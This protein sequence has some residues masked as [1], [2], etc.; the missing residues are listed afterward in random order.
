MRKEKQQP[1]R[2]VFIPYKVL[3]LIASAVVMLVNG[4]LAAYFLLLG[5]YDEYKTLENVEITLLFILLF[6]GAVM[7]PANVVLVFLNKMKAAFFTVLAA[8]VIIVYIGFYLYKNVSGLPL[9]TVVLYQGTSLLLPLFAG[10]IAVFHN[11]YTK[12]NK[13]VV[14]AKTE[15]QNE[16]R[17]PSILD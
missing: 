5:E 16:T 11:K 3:Y 17:A 14:F 9:S 13:R 12:K 6:A 2:D 7:I 4:G 8:A 15:A 10:I 1:E